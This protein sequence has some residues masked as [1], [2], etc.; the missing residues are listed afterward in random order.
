MRHV[1]LCLTLLLLLSACNLG[2]SSVTPIPT[3]DIPQVEILSPENNQQA[4]EGAEFDFDIVARDGSEGIALIELYVDEVLINFSSPVEEDSVPIFR[5][6]MNWRALGV[7]LHIIE[8][9]AYREDGQ[10]G[11]PARITIEVLAREE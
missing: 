2:T 7:G 8:V 3:P 6:T 11:D 1:L 9:I 10:Q 5:T 4:F